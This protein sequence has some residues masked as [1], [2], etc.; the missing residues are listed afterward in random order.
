[1][2]KLVA[3][4]DYQAGNVTSV[5]KALEAAG[6]EAFLTSL[7]GDVYDSDAVVVPGVGH[8]EATAAIDPPMR[9]CLQL[10]AGVRPILGICLGMQFLFEGS[11]EAPRHEGLGVLR[12]RC[13]LLTGVEKVPHVGWNTVDVQRES[14]LLNGITRP[15]YFYFTHSYVAPLVD[16]TLAITDYGSAFTAM[17]D[18]NRGVYGTQCHP[19]K[20]GQNGLRLLSNFVNLC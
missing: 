15:P 20:S 19:E 7:P 5:I 4:I 8:F 17:L 2:R 14:P 18:D 3:V 16:A 10:S 11:E 13:R 12:G 9:E 6:A 1:M